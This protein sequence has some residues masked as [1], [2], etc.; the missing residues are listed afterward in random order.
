MATEL[1]KNSD[2]LLCKIYKIYLEDLN[3][4]TPMS[5][6]KMIGSSKVIFDKLAPNWNFEDVDEIC[7]EL[8]RANFLHCMYADDVVYFAQLT[9][10]AIIHMENRF[11]NGLKDILQHLNDIKSIIP[12]I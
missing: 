11:K 2:A 9:D 12:F 6:A 7:R 5:K 4:G 3:N 1:T 8:D 10:S